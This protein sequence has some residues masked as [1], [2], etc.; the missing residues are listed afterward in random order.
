[1]L[2]ILFCYSVLVG[3]KEVGEISDEGVVGE[4]AGQL[5]YDEVFENLDYLQFGDVGHTWLVSSNV[6]DDGEMKRNKSRGLEVYVLRSRG[7][8]RKT[9]PGVAKGGVEYIK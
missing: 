1:V 2:W 3:G 4:D 9:H 6:C 5:T 7:S 8:E